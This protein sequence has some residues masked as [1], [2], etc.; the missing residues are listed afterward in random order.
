MTSFS[1]EWTC[2]SF[3]CE[4]PKATEINEAIPPL[5]ASHTGI[6]SP[7]DA[8]TA[9]TPPT[10]T[11]TPAIVERQDFPSANNFSNILFLLYRFYIQRLRPIRIC[12][13]LR[14]LLLCEECFNALAAVLVL[15]KQ[16]PAE[17]RDEHNSEYAFHLCFWWEC[18]RP[19]L[20]QSEGI[21]YDTRNNVQ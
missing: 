8:R 19:L 7:A 2:L 15:N 17:E 18:D 10:N 14:K 16:E 20:R 4:K 5:T 3:V 21:V 11:I 13:H 9:G 12:R 6:A 1:V